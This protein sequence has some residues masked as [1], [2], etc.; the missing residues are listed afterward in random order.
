MGEIRAVHLIS[1]L[2]VGGAEMALYRL[3]RR[4]DRSR[5]RHIVVSLIEPGLAAGLMAE[6]GILV[7][8]LGME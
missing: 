8:S 5:L 4:F 3:L 6:R 1:S 2:N 7:Y